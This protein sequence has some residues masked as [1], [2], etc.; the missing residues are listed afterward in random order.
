MA[1]TRE[2]SR[3][4]TVGGTAYRWTVR[5]RAAYHQ[6]DSWTLLPFVVEQATGNGA[7]LMVTLPERSVPAD[8]PGSSSTVAESVDRALTAGWRP[9]WRGPAFRSRPKTSRWGAELR[10][11]RPVHPVR[12]AGPRRDT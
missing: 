4:I 11:G 12:H 3:P 7:L 9:D 2:R 5:R 8:R 10:G 1:V 6:G